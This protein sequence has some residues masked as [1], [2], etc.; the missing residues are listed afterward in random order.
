MVRVAEPSEIRERSWS[1]AG[2]VVGVVALEVSAV[3]AAFD[4]AFASTDDQRG[5]HDGRHVATEMRDRA[6]VVALLDH[7]GEERGAEQVRTHAT[8]T[9][10]TPGISHTS[11]S[12]AP[13][14]MSAPWSTT[15]CTV[16]VSALGRSV[17]RVGEHERAKASAM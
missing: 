15:M 6:N 9:G 3:I 7:D 10:P 16:V 12:T 5:L 1:A 2:V 17:A 11:S 4:V 8:S 14:R 13:P